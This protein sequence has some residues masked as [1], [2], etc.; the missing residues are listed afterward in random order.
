LDEI[1]MIVSSVSSLY[2]ASSNFALDYPYSDVADVKLHLLG[3][4]LEPHREYFAVLNIT[5][6]EAGHLRESIAFL[7][8]AHDH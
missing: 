3:Q 5:P 7:L 8:A 2:V 4:L 1:S 6:S